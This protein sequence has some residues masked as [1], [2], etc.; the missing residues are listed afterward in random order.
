VTGG[1]VSQL[2]SEESA[3]MRLVVEYPAARNMK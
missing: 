2:H 1:G 3:S